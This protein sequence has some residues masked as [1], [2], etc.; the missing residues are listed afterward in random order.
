MAMT[1]W[2]AKVCSSAM[3][4]SEKG[5][6]SVR[7]ADGRADP[8]APDGRCDIGVLAL[9]LVEQI[10]DVQGGSVQDG[11]TGDRLARE[12]PGLAGL[13]RRADGA[14]AGHQP[15]RVALDAEELGVL[16]LAE[17]GRALHECGHDR[18]DVGR[19]GRDDP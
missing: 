10:G 8:L 14:V 18:L 15:H 12:R 13:Q 16:G 2:S 5:R 11:P 7:N 9:G 6:T 17:P 4:L 1:A 3:C 19:R